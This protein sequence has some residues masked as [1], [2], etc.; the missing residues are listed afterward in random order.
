MRA[1]ENGVQKGKRILEKTIAPITGLLN[2][3]RHRLDEKQAK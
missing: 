2:D 3:F 1:H